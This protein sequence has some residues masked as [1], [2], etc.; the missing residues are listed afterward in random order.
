MSELLDPLGRAE[1]DDVQGWLEHGG[2]LALQQALRLA[3]AALRRALAGVARRDGAGRLH[4][5]AGQPASVLA[6][7]DAAPDAP[8]RG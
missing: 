4:L 1:P 3:P 7:L 8:D 5:E 2:A 6:R